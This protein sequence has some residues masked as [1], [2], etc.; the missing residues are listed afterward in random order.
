MKI[1]NHRLDVA[2]WRP[3]PNHGGEIVPTYLVAHYTA[4]VNAEA[5]IR[6]LCTAP[7]PGE[8]GASAHLLLDFDG[9]WTQMVPFN[10]KA[11]H[12]GKSSWQGR[13]G[14]N[15][16]SIGIEIMNP[17]YLQ[18]RD[19]KAYDHAKR[20]WTGGVYHGPHKAAPQLKHWAAYTDEQ[21]VALE[22]VGQ[23]LVRE[24][25]LIDVL[26]HDDVA[27]GRK[28]DPGPAF[29]MREFRE[30]VFTG[31]RLD[32]THPISDTDPAGPPSFRGEP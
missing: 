9:T 6:F 13:S 22:E 30:R 19:G 18:I 10:A 24:Y 5:T 21:M 23:L 15:D 20:E 26:G 14:L 28:L 17:G 32:E 4:T 16:F 29:G 2:R 3:S 7:K 31:E 27:P 11:W 1:E 8:V 25:N 12:A